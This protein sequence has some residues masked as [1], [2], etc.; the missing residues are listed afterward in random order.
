MVRGG[1][2]AVGPEGSDDAFERG[3]GAHHES[4][5]TEEH[6]DGVLDDHADPLGAG[7]VVPVGAALDERGESQPQRGEAQRAEQRY[8]QLQCGDGGCDADWNK[9]ILQLVLPSE[10]TTLLQN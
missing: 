3:P 4:Q 2:Y 6:D 9:V 8:E 7:Y 5:G 1:V 10:Q